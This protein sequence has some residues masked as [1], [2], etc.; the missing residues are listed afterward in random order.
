MR[1]V[2]IIG[3]GPAGLTAAIYA[4]RANLDPPLSRRRLGEEQPGRPA[5]DHH[6][7]RELSRLPGRYPGPGADGRC[8]A[9]R[10]CASAPSSS[11]AT[12]T[13]VDLSS[14]RSGSGSGRRASTT[15]RRDR[16][17]R[18]LGE[19][20]RARRSAKPAARRPRRLAPAPPATA[21]SSASKEVAVVGGGD[22]AMEEAI[23]LTRSRAQGDAHP[24]PRQLRASKIMQDR[25]FANPKIEFR[26]E[27]RDR[28]D[29]RLRAPA[30]STG[31]RLRN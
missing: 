16:R 18:R 5:D 22:T 10:R 12:S 4:A 15:P 8:S 27:H 1:K 24:P 7:G 31:V 17:H 9:S 26:L 30:R 21:S 23:F 29:R 14:G 25:A 11:T 19:V 13:R 28:R 2:T 3:S 20:A 6:R